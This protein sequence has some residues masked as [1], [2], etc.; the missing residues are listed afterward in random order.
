MQAGVLVG[1]PTTQPSIWQQPPPAV[2]HEVRRQAS[3]APATAALAYCT[4][5]YASTSTPASSRHTCAVLPSPATPAITT[6][7]IRE[8]D[9]A[10]GM[11]DLGGAPP[12][13]PPPCQVPLPAAGPPPPPPAA[14]RRRAT[15]AAPSRAPPPG[16][17]AATAPDP[18]MGVPDPPPPHT[19]PPPPLLP[20]V[21][22]LIGVAPST[23]R[24]EGA[25][26]RKKDLAAAFPARYKVLVHRGIYRQRRAWHRDEQLMPRRLW[27]P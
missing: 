11:P 25:A 16:R 22:Y 13:P 10:V 6:L 3:P 7:A 27:R 8:L 5:P 14:S 15:V 12:E 19:A 17:A 21:G 26:K 1:S 4:A 9:P 18:A 23:S 2:I 20:A 24:R